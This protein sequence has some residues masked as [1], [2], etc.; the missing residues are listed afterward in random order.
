MTVS[1]PRL[2]ALA[3]YD[4]PT[5]G[6][7]RG[8]GGDTTHFFRVVAWDE[9][10][11]LRLYLLGQITQNIYQ[12]LLAILTR[13]GQPQ[14]GDI[15]TPKWEFDDVA[16]QSR[17]NRIVREA[18]SA[19]DAPSVFVLG[20]SLLEACKVVTPTQAQLESAKA[21]VQLDWPGSLADWL[22]LRS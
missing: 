7:V 4:G 3:F 1:N 10:Q 9:S 14:L 2:L 18:R 8:F 12:E 6:F 11:D 16:L 5:E 17:A 15:W 22:A 13:A 20:E 21:L 19:L